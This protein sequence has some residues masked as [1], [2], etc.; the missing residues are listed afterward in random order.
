VN[1]AMAIIFSQKAMSNLTRR[2]TVSKRNDEE[3]R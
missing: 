2:A 1:T 3:R